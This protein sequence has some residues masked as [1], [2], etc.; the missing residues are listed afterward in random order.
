MHGFS[1]HTFKFV[2][3]KGEGFWTKLHY[4]TA[5]GIKNLTSE[6]AHKLEASDPDYATRDLFEHI[7]SGKEAVWNV[8]AQFIPVGAEANLKYNIFD[9]FVYSRR[10]MPRGSTERERKRAA[11]LFI[12]T[13]PPLHV[14]LCSCVSIKSPRSCR[15]ETSR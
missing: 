2:N 3:S 6:E 8:S 14:S 11:W 13:V 15:T 5:A 4:K 1:S 7:A 10:H 9:S 12:L